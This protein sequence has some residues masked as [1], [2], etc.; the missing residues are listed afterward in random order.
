MT[1]VQGTHA[2]WSGYIA[3]VDV[4]K[5]NRKLQEELDRL[6]SEN[7]ELL[8]AKAALK[9]LQPFLEFK[10][11]SP[12]SIIIARVIGRD[13]TS[14]YRTMVIDKGEQDGVRLDMAAIVPGGVVGRVMKTASGT[15]RIQLLTDHNSAVAAFV[16][17]TRDEGIVEGTEKG[18]VRIKYLPALSEVQEGDI[19]LTSGLAGSFPK[20]L[21]IGGIHKVKKEDKALFQ[22][23][24]VVPMLD[25]SKLEEV[26]IITAIQNHEIY[27]ERAPQ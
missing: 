2:I 15:S 11:K 7:I 13:S 10:T 12:H 26:M 14:W 4:R 22:Q 24:D 21:L 6:R 27:S 3:L 17:R 20:G 9:R 25:F 23:A 18:L 5:E 1:V 16:Q 19:V 8:E